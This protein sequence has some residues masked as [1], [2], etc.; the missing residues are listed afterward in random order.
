MKEW[1][2]LAV[3]RARGVSN[4]TADICNA[5]ETRTDFVLVR[6]EASTGPDGVLGLELGEESL[7]LAVTDEG[8]GRVS[9]VL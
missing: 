1:S 7:Q 8:R 4:S 9:V 6:S 2:W 3:R 5:V